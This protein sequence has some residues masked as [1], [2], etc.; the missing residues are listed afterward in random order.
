MKFLKFESQLIINYNLYF[1][2]HNKKNSIGIN[3]SESFT[4]LTDINDYIQK[5]SIPCLESVPCLLS[6]EALR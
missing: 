1:A 6:C 3:D 2:Q 4:E 5:E